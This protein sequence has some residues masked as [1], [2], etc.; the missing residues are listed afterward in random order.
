MNLSATLSPDQKAAYLRTLPAIRERCGRVFDLATDPRGCKLQ[1]FDYH[2]E[3]EADVTAFC[4][5]IIK[6]G[7]YICADCKYLRELLA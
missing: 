1:Y 3:K 4:I 5:K 7:L 2:P 6:V